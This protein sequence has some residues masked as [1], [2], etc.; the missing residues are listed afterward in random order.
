MK[1]LK[2]GMIFLA[3]AILPWFVEANQTIIV[4]D[5]ATIQGVQDLLEQLLGT[6]VEFLI[7][8]MWKTYWRIQF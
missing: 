4:N 6:Q 5:N 2:F 3:F 8:I 1:E 7:S